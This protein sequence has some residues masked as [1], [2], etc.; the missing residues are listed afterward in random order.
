MLT[1]DHLLKSG[2]HPSIGGEQR[3]YRFADGHG[4]S[5][6]NSSMAH[7]YPFA[8]EAAVLKVVKDDGTHEGLTYDTPLTQDVEV[9]NSDEEANE[10]IKLAAA[11]FN[12]ALTSGNRND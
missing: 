8:W 2:P 1:D 5:L 3:I 9:F 7:S 10:F 12:A 4:L 11:H 6:I